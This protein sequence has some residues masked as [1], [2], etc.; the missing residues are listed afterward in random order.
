MS[1][2]APE[3]SIHQEVKDADGKVIAGITT[4]T[5][6]KALEV[7]DKFAVKHDDLPGFNDEHCDWL[8]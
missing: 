8:A 5:S 4:G 3:T 7:G 2:T 1:N 6:Q